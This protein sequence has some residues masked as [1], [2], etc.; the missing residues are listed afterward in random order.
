MG[1]FSLK[2]LL[3]SQ[4]WISDEK[5]VLVCSRGA[6]IT[7]WGSGSLSSHVSLFLYFLGL[8][9][10]RVLQ[11]YLFPSSGAPPQAQVRAVS[12]ASSFSFEYFGLSSLGIHAP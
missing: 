2:F 8:G 11:R 9:G 4:C 12:G 3:G 7:G 10:W 6:K 5:R 1:A